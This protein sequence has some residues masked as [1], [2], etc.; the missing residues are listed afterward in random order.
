MFMGFLYTFIP[1][2]LQQLHSSVLGMQFEVMMMMT[3]TMTMKTTA[4]VKAL[5]KRMMTMNFQFGIFLYK[6]DLWNRRTL[7]AENIPHFL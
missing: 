3:M 4:T 5:K 2:E 7:H 1:S 6:N